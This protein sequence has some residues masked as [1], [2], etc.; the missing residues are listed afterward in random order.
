[1]ETILLSLL[2]F[3]VSYVS[4]LPVSPA[5]PISQPPDDPWRDEPG[6]R[7]TF[8]L[9][10]SCVLTLTLCVYTE[11]IH[12]NVDPSGQMKTLMR[13]KVLWSFIALFSPEIVVLSAYQQW[14]QTKDLQ[15]KFDKYKPSPS[16]EQQADEG[17]T[18]SCI[19][20]HR[21]DMSVGWFVVMGGT[22]VN[23]RRHVLTPLGAEFLM[24][25]G[26]WKPLDAAVIQ[27]KGK[28][29]SIAKFIVCVQAAW[30]IVQCGLRKIA[31]LPITLIEL[32][33][34]VHVMCAFLLVE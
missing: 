12:L 28:A 20:R 33:A 5:I 21:K 17:E 19:K 4:G 2:V 24:K 31:G 6:G 7:G 23:G 29:D 25:L 22:T 26:L 11:A 10:R 16:M 30:M 13:R 18:F 14:F 1:M 8:G 32:N 3:L 9:M 15:L 34:L 27:D